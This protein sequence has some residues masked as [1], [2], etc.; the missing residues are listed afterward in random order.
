MSRGRRGHRGR[1]RRRV[2]EEEEDDSWKCSRSTCTIFVDSGHWGRKVSSSSGDGLAQS[3]P[4][5][6]IS[7]TSLT[8]S[9]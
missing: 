6:C 4:P 2:E 7:L 8:M 3:R 1:G 5:G 9:P